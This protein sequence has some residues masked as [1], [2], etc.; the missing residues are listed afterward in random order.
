MISEKEQI[1]GVIPND[2]APYSLLAGGKK[3]KSS[4]FPIGIDLA[5]GDKRA[6]YYRDSTVDISYRARTKNAAIVEGQV[7]WRI[8]IGQQ[9]L[10]RISRWRADLPIPFELEDHVRISYHHVRSL[11]RVR[12]RVLQFHAGRGDT[13]GT[14]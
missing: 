6:T 14:T 11:S 9:V 8:R 5:I 3:A 4:C 2:T 10:P 1:G 13:C 12:K 7:R